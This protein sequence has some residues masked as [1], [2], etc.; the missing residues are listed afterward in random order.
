LYYPLLKRMLIPAGTYPGQ[1]VPVHTI[2][3]DVLLVC[4]ADLDR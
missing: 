1:N 2:G 3:V 4:R